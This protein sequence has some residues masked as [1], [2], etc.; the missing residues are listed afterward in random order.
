MAKP[1]DD[2]L[3]SAGDPRDAPDQVLID[4]VRY[5]LWFARETE[6]MARP[7]YSA[8]GRVPVRVLGQGYS[9]FAIM[10]RAV[11]GIP[12]ISD[13]GRAAK[14]ALTLW[15][16]DRAAVRRANDPAGMAVLALAEDLIA[17]II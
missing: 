9:A 16:M 12:A 3:Y 1:P 8:I 14:M 2:F 17:K 13:R 10:R 15:D 11:S 7:E 6:R 4:G 5:A